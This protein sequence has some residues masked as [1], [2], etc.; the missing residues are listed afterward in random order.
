ML[1]KKSLILAIDDEQFYLNELKYEF[2]GKD[3]ELK[4]FLGHNAF[5]AYATS[6]DIENAKIILVDYDLRSCTSVEKDITRYVKT[7]FKFSGKIALISLLEDFGEDSDVIRK[8]YDAVFQ[9][10]K[11]S[12]NDVETLLAVG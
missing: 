12:W 1:T 4:T 8:N 11:F 7:C 2:A 6:T 10:E 5:E 9:K 3:V